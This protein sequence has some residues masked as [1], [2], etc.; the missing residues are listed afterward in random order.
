MVDVLHNIV[1]VLHNVV[2][3][4]HNMVGVLHNMVNLLHSMFNVLHNMVGI[5]H[6]MVGV[7]YGWQKTL[8]TVGLSAKF[9][10]RCPTSGRQCHRI[11]SWCTRLK[12]ANRCTKAW[13]LRSLA[14][15]QKRRQRNTVSY[16]V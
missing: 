15:Q 13:S 3:V 16:V 11:C 14:Q 6:N 4:L 8:T 2:D 9:L 5:L 10:R 7:L 12:S 1:G